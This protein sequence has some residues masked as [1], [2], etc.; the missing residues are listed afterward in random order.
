MQIIPVIDL[1]HGLV[2]HAKHGL[3]S[4]YAPIQSPLCKNAQIESV[5]AGYLSLFPFKTFY[6]ADL[7]SIIDGI[8]QHKL[9]NELLTRHPELT[10]WIDSGFQSSPDLYQAHGNY[11]PILGSEAYPPHKI[12]AFENFNE[13][14]ILSLDFTAE[15]KL[16]AERIFND[17]SLWPKDIILMTLQKVGSLAG[18]DF[19]K[20]QSFSERFPEHNFIAAG[21]VRNLDDIQR[22]AR[23]GINTALIASALHSGKFSAEQLRSVN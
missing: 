1:N 22:L 20:L 11:V 9:I 8:P 15:H 4:A 5:L 23:I 13:P 14:F 6:I 17:S 12:T 21:G 18:P 2:V 16:G 3:R 10:F 19:E 7:D